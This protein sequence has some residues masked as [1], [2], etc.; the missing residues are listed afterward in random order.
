MMSDIRPSLGQ[1][2]ESYERLS[3]KARSALSEFVDNSTASYFQ[4]K[5]F[6]IN[7]H[8]NEGFKDPFKLKIVIEYDKSKK[9]LTVTDNAMGMDKNELYNALK[10]ANRPKDTSGRNEFGMGLKTS[11]SWFS[12]KWEVITKKANS[13]KSYKVEVDIKNLLKTGQNDFSI[14]EEGDSTSRH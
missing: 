2:L 6:L 5:D 12:K 9:T 14:E 4:N 11:A 7:N 13:K 10:I 1:I 8:K 3:Y